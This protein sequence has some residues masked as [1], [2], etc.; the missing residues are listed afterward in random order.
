MIYRPFCCR[1]RTTRLRLPRKSLKN[2]VPFPF[3]GT[4][5]ELKFDEIG[6]ARHLSGGSA[7]EAAWHEIR[8]FRATPLA[9]GEN[10]ERKNHRGIGDGVLVHISIGPATSDR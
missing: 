7:V 8:I 5:M 9:R 1:N 10:N 2:L 3:F 6:N 4:G